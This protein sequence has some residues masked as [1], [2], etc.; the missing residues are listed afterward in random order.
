M[1]R[2]FDGA[3]TRGV[4]CTPKVEATDSIV[5]LQLRPASVVAQTL[6]PDR[7]L[8]PVELSPRIC[9]TSLPSARPILRI[10]ALPDRYDLDPSFKGHL[11]W[12]RGIPNYRI[13]GAPTLLVRM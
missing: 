6:D 13:S 4:P 7:L 9:N 8:S 10:S 1:I 3:C 12:L 11:M 2:G 5:P